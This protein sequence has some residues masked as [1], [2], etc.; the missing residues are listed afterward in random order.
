MARRKALT[1][2]ESALPFCASLHCRNKVRSSGAEWCEMHYGRIRR[3]GDTTTV[4]IRLANG[5]C[6]YCGDPAPRKQLFCSDPC[7]RRDRVGVPVGDRLCATCRQVLSDD[8]RSDKIYCSAEC[9]AVATTAR[10]YGLTARELAGIRERQG[11]RCAVCKT[12]DERLFVDHNHVSGAVRGL[13][14]GTCNSGIGMLK[15]SPTVLEAAAAYLRAAGHY[16]GV[17]GGMGQLSQAEPT[18]EEL[19]IAA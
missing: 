4:R 11:G 19:G 8:T 5:T 14:C 18:T 12:P 7:R 9:S 6:H 3:N 2:D 17:T 1:R 15:D 16:G 13:L 10:R